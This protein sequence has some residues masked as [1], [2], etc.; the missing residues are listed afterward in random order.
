MNQLQTVIDRRNAIHP[1]EMLDTDQLA[2]L[3][4]QKPATLISWRSEGKGPPFYKLGRR[5][6]YKW[7]DALLWMAA[8][9]RD[10]RAA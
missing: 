3:I 8:Q 5:V 7:E 9:R 2:P 6:T 1:D 10:P 4:L